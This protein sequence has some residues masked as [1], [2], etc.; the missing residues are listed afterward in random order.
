MGARQRRGDVE[1]ARDGFVVADGGRRGRGGERWSGEAR[2]GRSGS[3]A[4]GGRSRLGGASL[5]F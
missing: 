2:V 1:G 5:R 3:M 4:G